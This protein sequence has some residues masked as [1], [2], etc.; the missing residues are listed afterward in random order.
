MLNANVLVINNPNPIYF[1]GSMHFDFLLT[2]SENLVLFFE[3]C[4]VI[5]RQ[6]LTGLLNAP[7]VFAHNDL[8]SGNLMLNENEGIH[9]LH[10]SMTYLS[11]LH[12]ETSHV[13]LFNLF[14]P[15]TGILRP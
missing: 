8:L 12:Y 6:D 3:K 13:P 2:S 4:L 7:V 15:G 14:S 9:V 5:L 10:L 1:L 11:C